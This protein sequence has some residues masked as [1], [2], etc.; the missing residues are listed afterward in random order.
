MVVAWQT[1]GRMDELQKLNKLCS[2][3]IKLRKFASENEVAAPKLLASVAS[4]NGQ[5]LTWDQAEAS[6]VMSITASSSAE[7][8]LFALVKAGGAHY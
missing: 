5:W 6:S 3:P 2:Q 8:K 1:S 7:P 4:Q